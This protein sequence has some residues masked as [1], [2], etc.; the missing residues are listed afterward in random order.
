M[1]T[2]GYVFLSLALLF[3]VLVI[4]GKLLGSRNNIHS[5]EKWG[6]IYKSH[7]IDSAAF[8]MYEQAK[9]RAFFYNKPWGNKRVVPA[10]TFKVFLCLAALETSVAP[11][12]EMTIRYDG[13]PTGN[14]EW[15]KDLTMREALE[16]SSEPY[17][18]E[19]A[20][21]VGKTELKKWMDT[22]HYGNATIGPN[23][24]DCWHDG[25]VLIT[26]DEQVG[27]MKKLYFDE[28]PFSK[29]V[30]RIVRSMML[31]ETAAKYKLYHKTGTNV[32]D[33][34]LSSW[35]IGYLEDSTNHPY[36]FA[37]YYQTKDTSIDKMRTERL[38]IVSEILNTRGLM[39]KK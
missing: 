22:M 9:E 18:R 8:E 15:D 16:V 31:R 4:A 24:E 7:G 19:L 25:S 30:Q 20:K 14:A 21:R 12:E 27:F 11:S 10:S 32:Q 35:V 37:S 39:P 26:P 3:G 33:G 28:L 17:F 2:T 23:V 29:R 34:L 6:A 36:F 38:E 13:K 1:K 5:E